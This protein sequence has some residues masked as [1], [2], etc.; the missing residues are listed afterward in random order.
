MLVHRRAGVD[1][2][3][4][5]G[6]T[7]AQQVG[8][9]AWARHHAAV[10]RGHPDQPLRQAHTRPWR[11]LVAGGARA[12]RVEPAK[13]GPCGLVGRHRAHAA[14]AGAQVRHP[15]RHVRE[16]AGV[17]HH[18]A[19]A[20]ELAQ[21]LQRAHGWQH[22][23][24]LAYLRQRVGGRDPQAL[25]G[26]AVVVRCHLGGWCLGHEE[27]RVVALGHAG[28]RE[29][30]THAYQPV[31]RQAQAEALAQCGECQL[32]PVECRPQWRNLVQQRGGQGPVVGGGGVQKAGFFQTFAHRGDDEVQPA[33]GQPHRSAGKRVVQAAAIGMRLPVG[34]VDQPAREHT[35]TAVDVA[36]AGVAPHQQHL[37]A[38]VGV[39]VASAIAQ[40]HDRGR[41]ADGRARLGHPGRG[42]DRFAH[43]GWTSD[44]AVRQ[45]RTAVLPGRCT[46]AVRRCRLP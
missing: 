26:L 9:G 24:Q 1:H 32:A 19:N 7:A 45:E 22:Q 38:A 14:A 21:C 41:R 13:L 18:R 40:H 28:R 8:V 35:G 31:G 10:G 15:A 42:G 12:L 36:R 17:C 43:G 33:R 23:L 11:Q 6:R 39:G 30:V 3:P 5:V 20:A 27:V 2:G 4:F 25:H 34:R 44:A 37:H 29:P 16:R 46:W